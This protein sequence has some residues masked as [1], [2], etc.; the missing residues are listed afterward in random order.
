MKRER[1]SG[2]AGERGLNISAFILH[3]SYY[4]FPET[5]GYISRSPALPLPRS[6]FIILFISGLEKL[7]EKSAVM[8]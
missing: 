5:S 4:I 1:G 8:R 2:R 3:I 6:L 7:M